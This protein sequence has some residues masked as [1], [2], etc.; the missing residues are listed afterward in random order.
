MDLNE[1]AYTTSLAI[2]EC[3][4]SAA[5]RTWDRSAGSLFD[6]GVEL[7]SERVEPVELSRGQPGDPCIRGLGHVWDCA[8]HTARAAIARPL[9]DAGERSGSGSRGVLGSASSAD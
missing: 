8:P 6:A 2:V 1:P 4:T 3:V 5:G 7:R 9:R